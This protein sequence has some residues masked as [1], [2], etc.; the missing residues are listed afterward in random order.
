MKIGIEQDKYSEVII[1]VK[2]ILKL[3]DVKLLSI[4]LH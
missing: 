4:G 1:C 3:L 2:F